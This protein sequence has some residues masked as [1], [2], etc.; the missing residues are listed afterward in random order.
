LCSLVAQRFTDGLT[1]LKRDMSHAIQYL[2]SWRGT[3]HTPSSTYP[4]EEGHSTPSSAYLHIGKHSVVTQAYHRDA[5]QRIWHWT[6]GACG[7]FLISMHLSQDLHNSAFTWC[8]C[9]RCRGSS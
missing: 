1:L 3:C 5:R 8:L 7:G 6:R 4:P 9:D 2:P